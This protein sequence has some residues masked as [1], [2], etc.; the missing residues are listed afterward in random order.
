MKFKVKVRIPD[1]A[2]HEYEAEAETSF[3]LIAAAHERYGEKANVTVICLEGPQEAI[4]LDPDSEHA[5]WVKAPP[6]GA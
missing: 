5:D 4:S 2:Y 3:D 1:A 6:A